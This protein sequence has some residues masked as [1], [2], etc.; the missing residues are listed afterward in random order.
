MGWVS[1]R[2]NSW[3]QIHSIQGVNPDTCLLS[4]SVG[5]WR[6]TSNSVEQRY[7]MR[8]QPINCSINTLQ[9][10]P[11]ARNTRHGGVGDLTAS[12]M[13]QALDTVGC[14]G[15]T[16][17][18]STLADSSGI[19]LHYFPAKLSI[20]STSVTSSRPTGRHRQPVHSSSIRHQPGPSSRSTNRIR[21]RGDL[22]GTNVIPI[23]PVPGVDSRL[24]SVS[25]AVLGSSS[26]GDEFGISP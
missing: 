14:R 20:R 12:L 8:P 18:C 25:V 5:R 11:Q 17:L 22:A 10:V 2:G 16:S 9:M 19:L 24:P 6:T 21:R 13:K 1:S 15:L 4:V 3:N 7:C 26:R 23:D